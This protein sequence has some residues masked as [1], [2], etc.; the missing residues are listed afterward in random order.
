MN[1]HLFGSPMAE[2][3]LAWR[4]MLACACMY[5]C[6]Y[7]KMC[8]TYMNVYVAMWSCMAMDCH[9]W[10]RKSQYI[11]PCVW[12]FVWSYLKAYDYLLFDI[13]QLA[14]R[15]IALCTCT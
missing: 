3:S 6:M 9:M 10:T 15:C 8:A 1:K 12:P 4:N 13:S 7:D 5:A 2:T 14:W 11:W